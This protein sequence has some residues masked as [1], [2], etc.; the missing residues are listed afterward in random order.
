MRHALLLYLFICPIFLK[1]QNNVNYI[2]YHKQIIIAE[3]FFLYNNSK[4]ALKK[5]KQ[6]FDEWE[7]PFAKDC[8]IAA[9]LACMAKDTSN[10]TYFFKKCFENGVEWNTL[11]ASRAVSMLFAEDV[12]YKRHVASFFD[13]YYKKYT[14]RIDTVYNAIIYNMYKHEYGLRAI[15]EHSRNDHD[16]FARWMQVEDSNMYELVD[17][18]REKGFP[19]EKRIGMCY[20]NQLDNNRDRSLTRIFLSCNAATLFFHHRC[21][22]ELLK[23]QLM[24]AVKDGELHPR[25]YG[26]IYEW[27]HAYFSRKNWDDEYH[28]FKCER[29]PWDKHYNLYLQPMFYSKDIDRVNKDREEI[30]IS[31]IAHDAKKTQYAKDNELFL[32]F[33]GF[34][35]I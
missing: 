1:A 24:Q 12:S 8:Y 5:Y 22:Y 6:I 15:A 30:G 20:Y 19:G 29:S 16:K 2:D 4:A 23:E 11:L 14:E 13:E 26:L 10:A 7:Q 33:G 31:S 34:N 18:I 35:K 27:S 17:I 32:W 25:E 3:Q 21:G 9:Q 28:D